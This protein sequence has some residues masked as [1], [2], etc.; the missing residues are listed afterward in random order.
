MRYFV[1]GL[2]LLVVLSANAQKDNNYS[3]PWYG[4]LGLNTNSTKYTGGG[5]SI[6][7]PLTYV[8][9][10]AVLFLKKGFI[11][12]GAPVASYFLTG[13]VFSGRMPNDNGE[14]SFLYGKLGGDVFKVGAI[15]LGLGGSIDA[16]GIS[17]EGIQ[18]YGASLESYGTISPMVYAKISVG[19]FLVTPVLEYNLLTWANTD[20]TTRK[21]I[22]LG[23]HVVVPVSSKFALN[24]NPSYEKGN[25]KSEQ[26]EMSSSNLS[27]KVGLVVKTR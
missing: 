6:K 8:D 12:F 17:V 2:L 27:F 11:D 25:F 26:S 13:M 18:G 16:R 23:C 5:V 20:K 22:S 9:A 19:P 10:R 3:T 24:F 14:V 4:F 21:G 7:A 15:K 1:I